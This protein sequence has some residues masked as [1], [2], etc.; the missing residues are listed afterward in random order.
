M[1]LGTG[2]VQLPELPFGFH[3]LT[4]YEE[5]YLYDYHGASPPGPPFEQTAP[6]SADFVA[7]WT[8]KVYFAI[9]SNMNQLGSPPSE[10]SVSSNSSAT[11]SPTPLPS[12]EP[13]QLDQQSILGV[14]V[15][16]AVVA[17]GLGLLVYLIKRK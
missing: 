1:G 17:V 9:D 6:G 12:E 10:D 4:V 3:C 13:Q 7:S 8:D 16:V 15:T 2:L 14:A 11:P 5:A